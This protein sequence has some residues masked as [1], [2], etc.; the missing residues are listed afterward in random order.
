M[1]T[2]KTLKRID[3]DKAQALINKHLKLGTGYYESG[4]YSDF[5]YKKGNK[6][7]LIRE[8]LGRYET[9]PVAN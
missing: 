4:E 2:P 6:E 5:I 3:A 9:G 1:A 7:Y 8:F